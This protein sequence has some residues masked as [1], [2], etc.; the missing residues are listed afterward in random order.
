MRH[1]TSTDGVKREGEKDWGWGASKTHIEIDPRPICVRCRKV[2]EKRKHLQALNEYCWEC[3]PFTHNQSC[4]K[5]AAVF[6][7]M[8][9]GP[10]YCEPCINETWERW[11]KENRGSKIA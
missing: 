9:G 10:E 5:C 7:V 1:A 4:L 6:V 2:F 8:T 11:M 3:M